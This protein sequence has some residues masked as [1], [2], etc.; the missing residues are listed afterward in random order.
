[1]TAEAAG[2]YFDYSKNHITDQTI[3]LLLQL[4]D[5]LGK[6]LDVA[7]PPA[8]Q[9]IAANRRAFRFAP[10]PPASATQF[11]RVHDCGNVT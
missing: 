2:I 7:R 1:M 6:Q 10:A 11:P 3:E 5:S 8:P 9:A 4:A